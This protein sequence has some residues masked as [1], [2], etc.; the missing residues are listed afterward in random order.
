[1]SLTNLPDCFCYLICENGLTKIR[2]NMADPSNT[3][4]VADP[5]YD[6]NETVFVRIINQAGG[7]MYKF[8]GPKEDGL[9]LFSQNPYTTIG[10]STE[11]G[12]HNWFTINQVPGE[13]WFV[14]LD[15]Q[16]MALTVDDTTAGAAVKRQAVDDSN[17]PKQKWKFTKPDVGQRLVEF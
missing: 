13:D 4:Q 12:L 11:A 3:V 7:I 6:G 16:G 8:L 15:E 17:P 2:T 9:F 5:T 1:M 14:I 10:A